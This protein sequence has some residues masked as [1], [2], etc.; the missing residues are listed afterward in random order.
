MSATSDTNVARATRGE[1]L[2]WATYDWA[3]SAYSTVSI[4]VLVTYLMYV[5][6]RAVKEGAG[7]IAWGWGLGVTMFFAAVASPILG[8]MAD[9]RCTKRWWLA[10][11]ALT[12]A[13]ASCAMFF[14]TPDHPWLLVSLFLIANLGME[15]S[16][17]FYNAFLPELADEKTMGR[18][19]GWGYAL[20][21]VGGGLVLLG[22]I[23]MYNFAEQLGLPNENGLRERVALLAMGLW[24]AVFTLPAIIWV[25]DRGTPTSGG[26]SLLESA[27]R[28]F[29]EVG[30][31][32]RN[33]RRYKMLATF[34]LGFLIFNDG[35]QTVISQASV[36]AKDVLSME[37]KELAAVV[38]MIQF[39]ALPG[40]MLMA[41]V[42]DRI[43]QKPALS[44]CLG[45]WVAILVYAFFVT[46]TIEFWVMAAI[47]AM[48]L[49]GSQ[50]VSRAMMGLMTPASRTGE[51][52]G[53]FNFTGK[54]TSMF[55]PIIYSTVFAV[56]KS[57]HVAIAS[58]LVFFVIG[59][60]I[61]SRV[62]VAA[63]R[64]RALEDD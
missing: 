20:G 56:F 43:G 36:F 34:L 40:A 18:V 49:G 33:L 22:V 47:V 11:T 30:G 14:A 25:K 59:W 17:G 24:W 32:L 41:W 16:Q 27:R 62:D 28:A 13:G 23:L 12:G 1:I 39:V 3:N 21:Y 44:I 52:F 57:A 29:G 45:V 35:V 51:F 38:L 61:V 63:G 58:L 15:L 26:A 9:A 60:A 8:A 55:G 6:D 2:A 54:A 46:T 31:T 42:G 64:R 4:T 53:F 48:V 10:G 50:S 19:S 5:V 37:A 7:A